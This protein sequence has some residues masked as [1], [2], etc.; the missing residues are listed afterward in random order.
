M[1]DGICV[2]TTPL[3]VSELPALI[4]VLAEALADAATLSP[5][6]PASGAHRSLWTRFRNYLNPT[7]APVVELPQRQER[8]QDEI[9]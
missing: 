4:G 7:I 9:K 8:N 6:L 3:D 1:H 2:A 5:R